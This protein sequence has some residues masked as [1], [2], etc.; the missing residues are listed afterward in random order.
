VIPSA[1]KQVRLAEVLAPVRRREEVEAGKEYRLLGVR[2]DGGGPFHRETKAGSE[3]SAKYLY[4]VSAG[5]FIYSRLFA[6]RGAFGV[7]DA[8]LDGCYVSGEFPTFVPSTCSLDPRYLL[9]WF[10]L[11][12]TL[13]RVES[14]CSGSTPLTRNRYKEPYFLALDLPLPPIHEQRRIV[15]RIDGLAALIEEAQGLRAK[16]SRETEALMGAA[17]ARIVADLRATYSDLRL[18][19]VCTKITDG[20]HVSPA[21]VPQ[22]IP[23]ISVRNVSEMGLDFTTAKYVT[24]ADHERFSRKADVE[25]GDVLYTKGGTTGVARR[26]DTD[27]EFSIWVHVALLKLDR[28]L[29]VDGFVEHMLNAPSSKE[30]AQ[31][32]T[33]GS[34]NKDLGLTRMCNIV[35]PVPALPEQQRIVAQLDGLQVKASE[36]RRLQHA[37]T[38]DLDA[39]LP[40]VLDRAFKGEL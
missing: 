8:A 22:G 35:F 26:V 32:Y 4:R 28:S 33:R 40:S 17:R 19:D 29:V 36:L 9:L 34:S 11:P 30:Q 27:A 13:F 24:P 38:V 39:L 12:G 1:G 14:D 10:R 25:R 23:F 21:Y 16:A 31:A 15:A 6:W 7:I 37:F 5:D 3:I 18:G 2:L 20:P